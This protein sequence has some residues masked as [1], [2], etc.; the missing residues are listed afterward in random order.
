MRLQA[1]LIRCT[2]LAEELECGGVATEQDMLAVVDHFTR[3][4]VGK[5]RRPSAESGASLE[6]QHTQATRGQTNA[7]AQPSASTAHDNDIRNH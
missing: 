1:H 6:N 3:N 5:C 7:R 4:R 2:D